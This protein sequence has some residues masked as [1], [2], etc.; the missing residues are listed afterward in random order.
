[1]EYLYLSGLT[2]RNILHRSILHDPFG[3]S[4][5][6]PSS[7][8]TKSIFLKQFSTLFNHFANLFIVNPSKMRTQD[9]TP[10]INR[11]FE[12][13]KIKHILRLFLMHQTKCSNKFKCNTSYTFRTNN[14]NC[15]FFS[16]FSDIVN[17]YTLFC[18]KEKNKKNIYI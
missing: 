11:N 1:M 3:S 5:M 15:S 17:N 13:K 4:V 8:T 18:N 9:K 14:F 12:K 10:F 2:T 6:I 7:T 16:R